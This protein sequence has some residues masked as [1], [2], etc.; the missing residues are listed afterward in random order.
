MD[1]RVILVKQLK[2]KNPGMRCYAAEELGHVG[3]VSVV[4][5]LIKLLEDDHQ[6]VRSSVARALGEINHQSALAALIKA[7]SDPVG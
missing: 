1:S 6:E 2:D 7:L 4:P 5:Y 3:D